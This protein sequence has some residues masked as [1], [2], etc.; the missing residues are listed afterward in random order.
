M[1]F[2]LRAV[3]QN[4]FRGMPRLRLLVIG[5]V[6][7]LGLG[8]CVMEEYNARYPLKSD[9]KPHPGVESA[10][11]HAVQGIDISRWQGEIDWQQVKAAGTRF[12]FIK[13]TEG[14]DHV[15]PA[16]LRN[17][18]G[19][20]AAG[21]PAGAYHFVYWCRPA[22]EQ[23]QWFV[24]H[25]P[26]TNDAL[27]LPPVLD[28]EWNGHSKTCPKKVSRET[29]IE[30]MRVMLRELEAHTGRRPIIYTDIPFHRDVI[31]GTSE[32]EGYP[33]WIRSTAARPEERYVNRRWEFWQFTTTGRIPGIRGDVDRNAFYGTE[34]EFQAWAQGRYDIA[35]RQPTSGSGTMLARSAPPPA[36]A[37]GGAGSP[38]L[39]L[40]APMPA[41][42]FQP[43][44]VLREMRDPKPR[45]LEEASAE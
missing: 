45:P 35:M 27:T 9:M 11:R 14:G 40:Q 32:F 16:F 31:E 4:G 18:Q 41:G 30:K 15:D 42:Q 6:A 43:G 8:G 7:S 26:N 17:W 12:A 19:A 33:F 38:V 13:A 22:H 10:K 28:V 20:R 36:A 29:A 21:I 37:P 1:R 34:Q 44:P 2:A 23:A 5:A 39:A 24:Q 3:L 25:I